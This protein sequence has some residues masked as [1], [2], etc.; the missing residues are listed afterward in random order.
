[1]ISL[2][3]DSSVHVVPWSIE[4]VEEGIVRKTYVK[5]SSVMKVAKRTASD[6]RLAFEIGN[7][8]NLLERGAVSVVDRSTRWDETLQ[9]IEGCATAVH[10]MNLEAIGLETCPGDS[11][12]IRAGGLRVVVVGECRELSIRLDEGCEG[13]V[14]VCVLWVRRG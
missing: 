5:I 4:K 8:P 10:D 7:E 6:L 14:G 3:E 11:D 13:V 1:M 9:G 12:T 2:S